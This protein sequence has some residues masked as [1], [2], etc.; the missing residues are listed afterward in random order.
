MG[1]K[2]RVLSYDLELQSFHRP[3]EQI[4]APIR[5]LDASASDKGT[6]WLTAGG[7]LG[8]SVLGPIAS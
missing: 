5:A 8:T 1:P 3:L 2:G 6:R 4:S 7:V